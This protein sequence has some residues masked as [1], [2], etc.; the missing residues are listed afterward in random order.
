MKITTASS[1]RLTKFLCLLS[2]AM[3]LSAGSAAM[4]QT[5]PKSCQ[6]VSQQQVAGL[7]DRWNA[8]LKTL[9]ADKVV[10]NYAADAILVAT[11]A[12][13]P[14]TKPAEIRGYFEHFLQSKPQGAIDKR[15]IVVGC[16]TAEDVG[17]YTFTLQ[18]GSQVHARYNYIYEFTGGQWKIKLHHSSAMPVKG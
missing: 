18:D 16:N 12:N 17:T 14:L 15:V 11:F 10:A 6:K 4:A 5:P 7:F 3:V 9:D 1:S 8:S 13:E 2:V